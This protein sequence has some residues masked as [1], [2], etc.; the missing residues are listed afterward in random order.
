MLAV[1]GIMGGVAMD[2]VLVGLRAA[3]AAERRGQ[4]RQQLAA[5]LARLTREAGLATA[6]AVAEDQQLQFDGILYQ[7]QGGALQRT[8]GGTTVTLVQG[9]TAFD[10]NYVAKN[11]TAMTTP[12]TGSDLHKIR[13]AQVTI[14]AAQESEALSLTA[15]AFMRNQS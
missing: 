13:V 3:H 14:T 2:A 7:L 1:L 11:R 12:V 4:V 5:A 10:F 15:A 8:Q 6:V 9:V